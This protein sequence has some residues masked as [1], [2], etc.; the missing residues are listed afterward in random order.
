MIPMKQP[1]SL[2]VKGIAVDRSFYSNQEP[3]ITHGTIELMNS[4]EESLIVAIGQVRCLGGSDII[5]IDSFFLYLL[6]DYDEKDPYRIE[7]LPDTTS[8]YEISF[9]L[10]S[11]VPYLTEEIQIEATL[12]VDGETV[13]VRSPYHISRRTPKLR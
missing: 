12:E 2:I 6:P 13:Q 9:P 5:P 11:A 4:G 8:Q 1:Q 3:V 7:L 10:I